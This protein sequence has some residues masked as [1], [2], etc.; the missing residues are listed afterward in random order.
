MA[1]Q[2]G[3]NP[4][5]APPAAAGEGRKSAVARLVAPR[6]VA[7]IG[8]SG[9]P[10]GTAGRPLHYLQAHGYQGRIYPVNPRYP[11]IGGVTCYPSVE[12]LPETPDA[13]LVLLGPDRAA[14]AVRELAA[15]G[16]PASVIL[17]GGYGEV[18]E[19]GRQRQGELREAAGSM[20]LLGP[21][22]IGLVN[23]RLGA[24]LSPSGSLEVKPLQE[25]GVA[26]VSQS[27][28]V[29]GSLLSR[30]WGRG[31][32]FT[33][34][35]ST[36]NEADLNV[37]DFVEY[38]LADRETKVIAL[39][40]EGLR[41]AERLRRLVAGSTKPIV[42]FKVGRSEAG[43]RSA[44][45]H[46]GALA[47]SDRLYD[48]YFEQL[49]II[50]AQT[51]GDLLDISGALAT[52]RR[53]R[54]KRL[55]VLTS[56]GGAGVLVTDACGVAGFEAPPPDPPLVEVLSG[57]LTDEAS[58]ADR[59][60]VDVTLAGLK[61]EIFTTAIRSMLASPTYDALVVVV[62]SS[63]IGNPELASAPMIASAGESDKPL[64][65]YVSPYAPNVVSHLNRNGVPAFDTPEGVAAALSAMTR[66][67]V[68]APAPKPTPTKHDNVQS[69]PLNEREALDLF[70]SFG[71]P[72]VAQRAV[73]TPAEAAEAAQHLGEHVV[74]KVLSR[75]IAHKSEA[76]GV[77]T[78]VPA[79]AVQ[80]RAEE[81][82]ARVR[83]HAPNAEIEGLLVQEQ[84]V[85]GG[86]EMI[87]GMTRDPQ[88]G[89]A[90][91]LGAGGVLAEVLQDSILRLP[92]LTEDEARD[93]IRALKS[94]RLLTGYRGR[95]AAD[96][97]ALAQAIAAFSRMVADL[98]D[99][100][101]EA[102]TNPLFVLQAG[103]G[104]K[105]ADGVALLASG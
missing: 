37:V 50:R 80:P 91:L 98:G 31:I 105:A 61:P 99:R 62:G 56:T 2:T 23:V 33:T 78:N 73:A 8:A 10:T 76:G 69:G 93:M 48:A 34:L 5:L 25:G 39:Y 47:G 15:R 24:A 55:G 36:G 52:D 102:E 96:V 43:A 97:E 94:A 57:L 45:S 101:L 77:L 3:G 95:P 100:L 68:R 66:T 79:H 29:L 60:P 46:T 71:V 92:P 70:A 30:A 18:G 11:D 84:V 26:L 17:A 67:I 13:A 87:L 53:P 75:D 90:V 27:G 58:V 88:L 16:T 63:G 35:V 1:D 64:L 20:R 19:T 104:V 74:L 21:N 40:L 28:G 72:I 6:S 12:A 103:Q 82:L 14:T 44:T 54:G 32:G 81:L 9:N 42:A 49:G 65:A 86:V 4:H 59:N 89:S 83:E 38:F 51:F 85:A 41:D 7:L 22:T